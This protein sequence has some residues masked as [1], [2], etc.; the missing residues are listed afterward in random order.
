[1]RGGGKG[2]GPYLESRQSKVAESGVTIATQCW[3]RR[4]WREYGQGDVMWLVGSDGGRE[5][6]RDAKA[7]ESE[8]AYN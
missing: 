2:R 6:E 1:M 4:T 5:K 7:K 8:Y 3:R